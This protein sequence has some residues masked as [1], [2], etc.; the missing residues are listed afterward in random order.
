MRFFTGEHAFMT[1]AIHYIWMSSKIR[2]YCKLHLFASEHRYRSW[3]DAKACGKMA[4]PWI[5]R[6]G[7]HTGGDT[8][9]V[10]RKNLYYKGE[11][12]GSQAG[13]DRMQHYV[14]ETM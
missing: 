14:S 1:A 4:T 6:Q 12:L 2:A 13:V 7:K 8:A 9:V 10:D 11:W 5:A 3:V